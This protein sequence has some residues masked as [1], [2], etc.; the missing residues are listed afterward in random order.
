MVRIVDG[1][2]GSGDYGNAVDQNVPREIYNRLQEVV[3][4]PLGTKREDGLN[5]IK[6]FIEDM[7]KMTAFTTVSAA[8]VE[9]DKFFGS[10]GL[11]M[12]YPH[13]DNL[14]NGELNA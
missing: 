9:V 10:L 2:D 6:K 5:P 8:T 13:P 3:V 11:T 7:D 4:H 14:F 12:R 1:S